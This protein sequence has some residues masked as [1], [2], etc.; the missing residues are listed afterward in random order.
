MMFKRLPLLSVFLCL[1]LACGEDL[2]TEA[3]DPLHRMPDDDFID[4]VRSNNFPAL[5]SVVIRDMH[6]NIISRDSFEILQMAGL[7]FPELFVNDQG[8][9]IE[10]RVRVTTDADQKLM[11]RLSGKSQSSEI[12]ILE[13]DC[14]QQSILLEQVLE[15][16]SAVRANGITSDFE[17]NRA[18][19]EVVISIIENC[20]MPTLEE[21]DSLHMEAVW[22]IFQHA[23]SQKYRKKYF[24]H[25]K[26]AAGRGD[27]KA[28]EVAKMEDRI[29]VADGQPQRYGTYLHFDRATDAYEL[30]DLEAP[31]RVDARRAEVGLGPIREFLA[32][33]GVDFA[34]AQIQ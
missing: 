20:G 31:E 2:S 1:L 23:A 28:S 34:V 10:I 16:D 5:D 26:S 7:Y 9:I 25:L 32:G 22:Q 24:K 33:Y 12:R 30:Y 3:V 8:K 27:L 19:L 6:Y 11:D 21:V 4:L 17:A 13:V 18:N 14:R 29:L 15:R